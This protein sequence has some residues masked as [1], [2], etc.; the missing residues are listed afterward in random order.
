MASALVI[1]LFGYIK[2]CYNNF[3]V[4]RVVSGYSNR[5]VR[6]LAI[7]HSVAINTAMSVTSKKQFVSS[8]SLS[9]RFA[10][11]A[12]IFSLIFYFTAQI[13]VRHESRVV[14]P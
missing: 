6:M 1:K 10:L 8:G 9:G 5:G 2:Q 13:K 11:T 14:D 3:T 7:H 12:S 4:H